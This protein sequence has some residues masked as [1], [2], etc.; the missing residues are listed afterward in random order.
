LTI[1]LKER[2]GGGRPPKKLKDN[3][4]WPEDRNRS[5][6]LN[7]GDDDQIEDS[8]LGHVSGMGK[9]CTKDFD[10]KTC[11]KENKKIQKLIGG[12]Y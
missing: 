7:F 1:V 4:V 2:G 11:R 9:K 8:G 3:F 10:S 12:E 6:G 5:K